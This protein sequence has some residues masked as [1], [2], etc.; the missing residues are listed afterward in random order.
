[1]DMKKIIAAIEEIESQPEPGSLDSIIEMTPEERD[2]ELRRLIIGHL[3]TMQ[4]SEFDSLIAE[5]VMARGE[6]VPINWSGSYLNGKP[7]ASD[8][9]PMP[10]PEATEAPSV[11][12]AAKSEARDLS[13]K[14]ERLP[15]KSVANATQLPSDIT[16]TRA[17]QG[18]DENDLTPKQRHDMQ[19]FERAFDD[20]K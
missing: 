19:E 10:R 9:T 18:S 12:A 6:I 11:P 5:V 14:S 15:K 20:L 3:T 1:M 8:G 16:I 17:V 2:A 13:E 7:L 4:Q